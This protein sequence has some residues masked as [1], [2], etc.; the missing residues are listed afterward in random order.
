M[1]EKAQAE[2]E[3]SLPISREDFQ[4]L[5]DYLEE[6]LEEN[7]CDNSLALTKQFWETNQIK[8]AE[9]VENWLKENGGFCDCEVLYKM[10]EL[11]EKY[12]KLKI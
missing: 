4:K 3:K 2:F 10:E 9:E 7:N 6:N 5:F 11:F 12:I 1:Q 8:N